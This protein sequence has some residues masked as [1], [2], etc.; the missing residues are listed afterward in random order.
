MT[1]FQQHKPDRTIK[2][3]QAVIDVLKAQG[4]QE[5]A[6]VGYCYGGRLVFDLAFA[7]AIKVAA[8]AHPSQLQAADIERYAAAATAPLLI[9]SC[10]FDPQFGEDKQELADRLFK[11]FKFGYSRRH[12]E[13]ATHGFGTRGDLSN[14][15]VK[16]AKEGAF[17]NTVEWFLKYL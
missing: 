7:G 9:N 10:E 17:K 6:A 15:K 11:D 4:V 12:F 16:A 2:R 14:P 8:T 3:V 13:G 5:F 1:W